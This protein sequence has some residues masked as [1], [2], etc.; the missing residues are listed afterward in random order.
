M[1][2]DRVDIDARPEAVS[3]GLEETEMVF[4]RDG[5]ALSLMP[6]EPLLETLEL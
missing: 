3:L 5:V 2:V 6:M 4:V 1:R